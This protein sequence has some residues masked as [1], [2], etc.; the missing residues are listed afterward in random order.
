MLYVLHANWM[1]LLL[2]QVSGSLAFLNIVCIVLL[3]LIFVVVLVDVYFINQSLLIL[4]NLLVVHI[5]PIFTSIWEKYCD[6]V[7]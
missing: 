2:F 6:C 4:L 1:Y 7:Q 3:K 5:E